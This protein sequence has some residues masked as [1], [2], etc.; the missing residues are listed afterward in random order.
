MHTPSASS[1][2][3]I[4][5]IQF[6]RCRDLT[7]GSILNHNMCKASTSV[8]SRKKVGEHGFCCRLPY[9]SADAKRQ[10]QRDQIS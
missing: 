2:A 3:G 8:W 6:R 4:V 7:D 5:D 1:R 9:A 10:V